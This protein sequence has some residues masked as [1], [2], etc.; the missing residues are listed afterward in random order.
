MNAERRLAMLEPPAWSVEAP[1]TGGG[2]SPDPAILAANRIVGFQRTD[3]RVHP[4]F[5]MRSHLLKHAQATGQRVFAVTSVGPGDG[6]THVTMN[7][8]AALSRIYPTVLVE[9]DLHWPSLGQRIGLP[10]V[11]R[12]IDDYLDGSAEPGETGVRV[13]G[14]DLTLHPVRM[15]RFNAEDLLASPRLGSF[16]QG[17][18]EAEGSPICLIDTP[19]ALVN[20]DLT[21]IARA[22]D[23]MLMVVQEAKTRA[24]ALRDVVKTLSPT[25]LVGSILNMSISSMP[26][27]VD[28]AYYYRSSE[29]ERQHDREPG[30]VVARG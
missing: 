24:R 20:D 7:L 10:P 8:A 2:F 22:V 12:G 6:K 29:A 21:L 19:P 4:F 17:L 5:V 25:P 15:R 3:E 23:G 28:H 11:C 18:R 26:S 9:L 13:A 14:F 30:P 27:K 16:I 1:L